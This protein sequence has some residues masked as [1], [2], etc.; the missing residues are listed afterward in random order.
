MAS[1]HR[2][3]RD[4]DRDRPR[5][6]RDHPRAKRSRSRSRNRDKEKSRSQRGIHPALHHCYVLADKQADEVRHRHDSRSPKRR[7]RDSRSPRRKPERERKRPASPRS[8]SPPRKKP[9]KE[10]AETEANRSHEK[11]KSV[12]NKTANGVSKKS[13]KSEAMDIDGDEE[14]DSA[15]M[16]R[17]MGFAKFRSTKQ[18]KVPNN[19]WYCVRK[20]KSIQY[21]QYMN[22]V[23]G[24]NR[25]LSPSR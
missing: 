8:R 18:T 13:A 4:R 3:D 19:D 2:K 11:T 14:D 22:R 24:F 17:M 1:D 5:D 7:R 25:P 15:M 6:S 9:A 23:G 12:N 21:R 10:N 20:D 16:E